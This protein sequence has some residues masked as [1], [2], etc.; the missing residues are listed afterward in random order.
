[1]KSLKIQT[2]LAAVD[3]SDH[4][5]CVMEYAAWVGQVFAAE[6]TGLFVVDFRKIEGPLLRDYLA[7]VGLDP[8]QDYRSRILKFYELK[9]AELLDRFQERCAEVGVRFRPICTKGIVSDVISHEAESRSLVILG[10]KGEHAEWACDDLGSSV[11]RVVR[12]SPVPVLVTPKHFTPISRALVGFDGGAHSRDALSLAAELH[13]R[14]SLEVTVLVVG[15][16]ARAEALQAEAMGLLGDIAADVPVR[17]Q[18]GSEVETILD[19]AQERRCG[20]VI[21]GTSGH[22]KIRSL[23]VGATSDAVLRRAS[24]PVLLTR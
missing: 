18:P 12:R 6:V 8:T 3:P 7:T 1:M 20:L 15:E 16:G 19:A 24:T 17:V 9:G 11:E 5:R 23:L 10:R 2:I 22:G 4:G 21:L 14:V 13:R